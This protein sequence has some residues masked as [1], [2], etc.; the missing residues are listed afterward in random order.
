MTENK[1]ASAQAEPA[2]PPPTPTATGFTTTQL[3]QAIK[4]NFVVVSGSALI[5]GVVLASTFVTSYLTVFDWHLL[6]FVQY[7]DIITFGLLG[8]GIVSGSLII[9][10]T[11]T[12]NVINMFSLKK[13]GQMRWVWGLALFAVAYVVFAMW[14]AIHRGEG[15]F[16]IV[17]SFIA[18][19]VGVIVILQIVGY[20]TTGTVPNI[21]QFTFL[22]VLVLAGAGALG[23]WLGYSVLETEKPQDVKLKESE[24]NGVKVVIVMSRHTI[25]IKDT[26]LFIV[27][28]NDIKQF[29]GTGFTWP[30]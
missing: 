10:Q 12:Q 30:P 13:D 14:S 8:L 21:A 18:L 24:M 17:W 11:L 23:Q 7:T 9:L 27:P 2:S 5:F 3:I 6:W 16:H 4:E 26:D 29:H 28:T 22:V 19:G 20:V 15:Y 1:D 25:F